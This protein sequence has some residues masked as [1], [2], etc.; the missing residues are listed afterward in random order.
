MS[1]NLK[2]WL[3]CSGG[4]D[5]VVLAHLLHN[6]GIQFGIL[7][8]NFQLRGEASDEDEKWVRDFARD[9]AI[10][11]RVQTFQ[12]KQYAL[13][14]KLNTQLAARQLRYNW[15]DEII[16]REA[17]FVLLA[18]HY[19]DQMET[20]F[21]QLSRGGGVKALAA[22][23]VFRKKY[24]RP[25]LKYSKQEILELA[26]KNNWTWREDKSN[27]SNDY[28][29]NWYRNE[30]LPWLQSQSF[31][32]EKVVPLVHDFQKVYHFLNAL[33]IP[34][35]VAVSEWNFFP[36]WYKQ[37]LLS[38]HGLGEFSEKEVDRL[39]QSK[40]GK[41]LGNNQAKI[42]NE[43]DEFH[44]VKEKTQKNYRLEVKKTSVQEIQFNAQDLF[45]DSASVE[46]SLTF[47]PWKE[48]DKFTPFGMK[49]EKSVGKF[50]RDRKVL[51]HLKKD[52]QI[53]TDEKHQVL[54][55]FGF[56][57]DENYKVSSQT[58]EVIWIRLCEE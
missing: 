58:Q 7:H 40:K 46:G 48:G 24:V 11:I 29:R 42:W 36:I 25:L 18:H 2:Y 56:G 23:P 30:V 57:V 37:W 31:P 33:P 27:L 43:G 10:P 8:C 54:G 13:E 41:Y 17:C 1:E 3:A 32:L 35:I 38:A 22:M 51:S 47:R 19:D 21:L 49:G 14:N 53:L 28:K 34:S 55:V 50:L 12:T 26:Q 4:V 6:Q 44:F 52:V 16:E 5:S 39:S 9:L 45:L 20:F 15:F